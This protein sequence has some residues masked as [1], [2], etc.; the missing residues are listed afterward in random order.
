MAKSATDRAAHTPHASFHVWPPVFLHQHILSK[1]RAFSSPRKVEIQLYF[2]Y[3]R[4]TSLYYPWI[5]YR[6]LFMLDRLNRHL[7]STNIQL[8]TNRTFSVCF[9]KQ[10]TMCCDFTTF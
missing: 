8:H 1:A 7:F 2:F 3:D 10:N 4:E 6:I 5:N 9:E